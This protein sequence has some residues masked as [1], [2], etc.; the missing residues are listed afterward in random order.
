MHGQQRLM[1]VI[2]CDETQTDHMI[3]KQHEVG[4]DESVCKCLS[5]CFIEGHLVFGEI[6]SLVK[7]SRNARCV[8]VC[9]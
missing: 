2:R 8:C 4:L 1:S 7:L 6:F 3:Q 5:S 9:E